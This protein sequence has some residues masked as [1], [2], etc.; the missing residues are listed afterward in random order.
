M[1]FL[2]KLVDYPA[3]GTRT[4]RYIKRLLSKA[5]RRNEKKL[6]DDAP[7]RDYFKGWTD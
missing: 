2:E 5:R 6:G 1:K 3:S 4:R 7:R